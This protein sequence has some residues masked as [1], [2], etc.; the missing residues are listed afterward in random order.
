MAYNLLITKKIIEYWKN[1]KFSNINSSIDLGD[2]DL[3]LNFNEIKELFDEN[4]IKF[5]NEKFQRLTK[6]P[7]R[8]RV[9]SSTLWLTLGLKNSD[10]IDLHKLHR[11][12]SNTSDGKVFEIDLNNSLAL[13]ELKNNYDLVTDF[14]NNEHVFNIAEA[15]TTT[16]DLCKQ[17]GLI[18]IVQN[19]HGGNGLYNFDLS[20]FELVAAANEYVIEDSFMIVKSLE[21][22]DIIPID[23]NVFKKYDLN[24][25]LEIRVSYLFRKNN[26]NKF[27]FPYQGIGDSVSHDK[28]YELNDNSKNYDLKRFYIPRRIGQIR[29][30]ILIKEIINR[31]KRKFFKK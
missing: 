26:S 3:N 7:S 22:Q 19:L 5:D 6:F 23:A 31:I 18:W 13:K 15:F 29:T 20:Y 2:Q 16:H 24:S 8:P 17:N 25:V 9:P 21:T 27:K 1:N 11:D 10:R 14:G 28:F 12:P 4:G 30:K